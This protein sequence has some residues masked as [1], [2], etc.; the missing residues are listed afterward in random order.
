MNHTIEQH[1]QV[2]Y[3]YQIL[4]TQQLFNPANQL[5]VEVITR[6]GKRK[7][8]KVAVVVDAGVATTHPNLVREIEAFCQHNEADLQ[9][10]LPPLVVTGGESTKNTFQE[11]ERVLE[12]INDGKIDRHAFV[13]AIGGGAVLDMAGFAAG[14]GHRG[15]GIIRVPTTVLAQNDAG[16]GVKNSINYFGKKNFLG[17]FAPPI[18]VINDASFLATL[19]DRQ[20][21]AG[22]SEAIKVALIKDLD[23]FE[24]IEENAGR[25]A[26]RE[27]ESMQYL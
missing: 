23:F 25:L 18:A 16:V 13:I 26:N 12:L 15:I 24:W 11:V 9:L 5:L 22:I 14:I 20:W 4:F 6:Q 7:P 2:D 17:T 21:R 10:S 1:F 8:A 27:L 3:H 19:D